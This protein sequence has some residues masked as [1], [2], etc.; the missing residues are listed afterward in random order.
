VGGLIV[1]QL[2]TLY[3]TPVLYLSMD[4]LGQWSLRQR[5]RLFPKLFGDPSAG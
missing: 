3:T 2:L 5:L 4:R 1:S